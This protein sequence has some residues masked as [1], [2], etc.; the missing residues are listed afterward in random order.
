MKNIVTVLLA[1]GLLG[2]FGCREQDG[3]PADDASSGEPGAKSP[4]PV[5][6]ERPTGTAPTSQPARRKPLEL[7]K[8]SKAFWLWA[9]VNDED[10]ERRARAAR[11]LGRMGP[12]AKFAVARL[13]ELL[14]DENEDVRKAA[15]EA[16]RRIEGSPTTQPVTDAV[17]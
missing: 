13:K 15:A 3:S 4:S 10:P 8:I 5:A 2:V 16:L 14:R 6:S 9:A 11:D 7:R 12:E 1:V 17:S